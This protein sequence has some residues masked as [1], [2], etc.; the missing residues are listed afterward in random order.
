MLVSLFHFID[1][2]RRFLEKL[3]N[4]LY[5]QIGI[6]WIGATPPTKEGKT[7][8]RKEIS[9]I[10]AK[11]AITLKSICTVVIGC[12][13]PQITANGPDRVLAATIVRVYTQRRL[14]VSIF[15]SITKNATIQTITAGPHFVMKLSFSPLLL[16]LLISSFIPPHK[17]V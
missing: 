13:L 16:S 4:I 15:R 7:M 3:Q 9:K 10:K 8:K 14:T 11:T 17:S 5:Y 12:F 2:S 1:L 6:P